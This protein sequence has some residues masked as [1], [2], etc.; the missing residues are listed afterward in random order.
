MNTDNRIFTSSI[1]ANGQQQGQRTG[2][3]QGNGPQETFLPGTPDSPIGRQ[4]PQAQQ[5]SNNQPVTYPSGLQFLRDQSHVAF[6][7][8]LPA[9]GLLPAPLF[10]ES[11]NGSVVARAQNNPGQPLPATLCQDGKIY[12]HMQ[13]NAPLA[14]FD[15]NTL[16]FGLTSEFKRDPQYGT[17]LRDH[18]QLVAPDG[19]RRSI[20]N[21]AVG[22]MP[23]QHQFTEI[24]EGPQ[25]QMSAA[26][27]DNQ[28]WHPLDVMG[29]A[30]QGYTVG[31]KP[32]W[33]Q[34]GQQYQMHLMPFSACAPGTLFPSVQQ[35][36]Q[37]QP[38]PQQVMDPMA[39]VAAALN[40]GDLATVQR[41]MS[42]VPPPS[43]PPVQQARPQQPAQQARQAQTR[44]PSFAD[45]KT[46][47]QVIQAFARLEDGYTAQHTARVTEYATSMAYV[48][49]LPKERVAILSQAAD[50]MDVGKLDVPREVLD[51]TGKYTD[52]E[53][54][55][56]K[57]H[58]DPQ[59]LRPY[60][61][62]FGASDEV[63]IV[64]M[65]HHE[66][67]DGKGYPFGLTADKIPF[68]ASLLA[69]ADAFD[70]MTQKRWNRQDRPDAPE[71][72]SPDKAM[73]IIKKNAGTQFHPAAVEALEH[74]LKFL[75]DKEAQASPDASTVANQFAALEDGYTAAHAMRVTDYSIGIATMLGLPE[76][77]NRTLIEAGNVFDM[78]KLEVPAEILD[79]TGKYTDAEFAEM[80]K[81][82]DPQ[83][84]EKYFKLFNTSPEAREAVLAHHEQPD[85]KGYPNGI[86]ALPQLGAILAVADA[87]DS[88]TQKRFSRLDRPDAPEAMP[89]ARAL[90]ILKKNAGTQ[91]DASVVKAFEEVLR[92]RGQL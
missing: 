44:P 3:V 73:E 22:M 56:M 51:K 86:T 55:A 68:E 24:R 29:N 14:V 13:P 63:G 54:A 80:K 9:G 47:D 61:E 7:A 49:G 69:V 38:Q 10:I 42:Q 27:W 77:A 60:L 66:R 72:M 18:A 12:V 43:A 25:G 19:T 17:T 78:G 87:Y 39:E 32:S 37:P 58:V 62:M 41:I 65:T 75:K 4:Q 59:V 8:V 45:G 31:Q 79:K 52:A 88:M 85:G 26:R 5:Q 16:E 91:F 57:K 30:F 92:S 35:A 53:F 81:H 50:L 48:L 34:P 1:P 11:V 64:V 2:P 40:R 82:I 36:V 89:P 21:E 33:Y 46:Q 84:M 83:R 67:P 20:F 23:G 76:S 90:D 71:A 15:P 6:Q 74:L 28:Q 70:S